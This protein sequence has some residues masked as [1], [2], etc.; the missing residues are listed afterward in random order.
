MTVAWKLQKMQKTANC[1]ETILQVDEAQECLDDG[2][3]DDFK[4]SQARA[5]EELL[6]VEHFSKSF[7]DK[8]AEQKG[9]PA[10]LTRFALSSYTGMNTIVQAWSL[11]VSG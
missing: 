3:R 10:A 7:K 9:G 5:K 11:V 8:Y 1:T 4:K 2:D 6:D